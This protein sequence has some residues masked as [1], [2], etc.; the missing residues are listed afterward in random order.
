MS[1]D[2]LGLYNIAMLALENQRFASLSDDRPERYD[3]DEVYTR[4]KGAI[5]YFL[6][7]GYWNFAMRAVQMDKSTSVTP[8][9]GFV[10]AFDIPTDFVRLNMISSEERFGRPLSNYEFEGDFIYADVD[11]LY[12]R[13]VSDD[14]DWGADFGKWPNTFSLWAGYWMATQIAGR[15]KSEAFGEKLEKKTNK[16]L[17]DARSKDV[18]QEPPRW[19]PLSTWASSRLGRSSRRDRGQ[20]GSLTGS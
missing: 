20:T 5:T 4:G 6:E 9:F 18:S 7:Q 2:K 12:I 14:V 3:L 15:T 19:P 17:I 16:L 13:Y 8:E 10:F 11:P 1:I